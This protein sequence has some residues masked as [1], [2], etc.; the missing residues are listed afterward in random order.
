M[1][2]GRHQYI[3]GEWRASAGAESI[4]V[5]NPATGVI[6]GE[7]NAGAVEDV[8]LAVT[9]ARMAQAGW[10]STPMSERLDLLERI[11]AGIGAQGE[12]L[13]ALITSEMGCPISFCRPAQIGLPMGDIAATLAAAK[14]MEERRMGRSLVQNDPIGVVAA[15]TPWNFPLHQIIAKVGPALAAGCTVV[16]KPSEVTPLDAALLAQ[17]IHDAGAPAGVFNLVIGGR[18]TGEA[19]VSHPGVDMVSFTGSTRGGRK[20][21]EIAGRGLKKVALELGGKSANILLEDADLEV[22]VPAALG[23]AFI[24]SGQVCAALS[25]L[26]VPRHRL[27]D[28][29]AVALEAIKGWTP[30]DPTDPATRM[31]PLAHLGQQAQVRQAV[32]GAQAQGARLV[33]GGADQ[34]EQTPLGAYVAATILSDV[35]ATMDIARQ[36]TFGPVLTIETYADEDEAV[37]IA[38]DSDYGLS[39]GVWS[40]DLDHAESVARRLRTG[41]VI[42]NGAGLDLAAPFGGVRNSGLGRENGRYGLEEFI[43]PKAITRPQG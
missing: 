34:P 24:N 40:A 28:V 29:E 41:Q 25:R 37:R 17:I 30:G 14:E 42:L 26:V 10:A 5:I 31:G 39:G 27:A 13:A 19:L 35:L 11:G 38:N 6:I 22:A 3:A 8:D 43:A 32:I 4:A 1:T 18:E 36:E 20:V 33:A 23:Q 12:E 9:A 21:A 16:L 15:I 2:D 7:A